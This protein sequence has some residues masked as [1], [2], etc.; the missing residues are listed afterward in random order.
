MTVVVYGAI[1]HSYTVIS[2]FENFNSPE[3]LSKSLD[4]CLNHAMLN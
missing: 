4:F 2:I 3:R 1:L